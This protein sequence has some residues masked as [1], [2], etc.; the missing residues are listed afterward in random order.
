MV[1][2]GMLLVDKP[3]GPTSHDVVAELRRATGQRRIGHTGT[4]DPPATGLLLLLLGQA[5]RLAPYVPS[6]PKVY[7]GTLR[8][9][10]RTLTDDLAGEPVA[11][12]AGA[13]PE[14][15]AVRAA[16]QDLVG[17]ILQRPPSVSARRV[18]GERLHRA[19]RRGVSLRAP[20]APVRVFRFDVA[21][22]GD[23]ETWTFDAEVSSGT[24]VRSL[25]RDLGLALGCGAAVA[26]LRRTRIGPLD[27]ASSLGPEG[28]HDRGRVGRALLPL[29]R[30]PLDALAV[31]VSGDQARAFV[32]GRSLPDLPHPECV[33]SVRDA[34]G[35]LLGIGVAASG[36]VSPRVVLG[37]SPSSVAAPDGGVIPSARPSS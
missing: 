5:T 22:S 13:L 3:A 12:H 26:T 34:S 1:W 25:V 36:T 18:R 14:P 30:V 21:P 27:V 11:L 8:L 6:A 20:A 7:T 24:F 19:A 23:P 31:T 29:D 4:L 15:A 16:A 10:V 37:R 33:V 32:H 28:W 2:D 35:S 9:G 17:E